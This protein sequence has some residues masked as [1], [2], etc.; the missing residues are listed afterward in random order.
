MRVT[1]TPGPSCS[2]SPGL[3][4]LIRYQ[5]LS[6]AGC[7]NGGDPNA[8][9]GA[10]PALPALQQFL[11]PPIR[12]AK[13][14]AWGNKTPTAPQGLQVRA[15]ATG[16]EHPRSV[17]VLPNGDVLVVEANGPKSPIYRPK[18]LIT[19]WVQWFAGAK[20]EGGNR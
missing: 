4:S 1:P 8:E 17:Y 15:L 7:D 6:L 2:A 12:I 3:A 10:N 16:F 13:F 11:I 18:D 14:A 19:H 20:G 9:I 5:A